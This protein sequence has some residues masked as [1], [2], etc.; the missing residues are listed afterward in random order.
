M[1][2]IGDDKNQRRMETEHDEEIKKSSPD[3]LET[4]SHPFT[5]HNTR[6]TPTLC[7]CV[8]GLNPKALT[9]TFKTMN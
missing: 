6:N 4:V 7:C 9:S 8:G 2:N 1:T 3:I 5:R